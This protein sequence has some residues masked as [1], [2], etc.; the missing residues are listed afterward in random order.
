[1]DYDETAYLGFRVTRLTYSMS[2]RHFV[3]IH[4]VITIII[5]H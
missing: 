5:L 4:I 2:S 1:M 3:N